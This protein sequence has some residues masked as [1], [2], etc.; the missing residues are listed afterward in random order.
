[1]PVAAYLKRR[2]RH[3]SEKSQ[4]GQRSRRRVTTNEVVEGN[5]RG[6]YPYSHVS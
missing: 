2:R 5:E 3:P 4:Q 1:M 6:T